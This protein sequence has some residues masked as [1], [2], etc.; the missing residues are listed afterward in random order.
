MAF[1]LHTPGS[2]R[3][4]RTGNSHIATQVGGPQAG[5]PVQV[6]DSSSQRS[7][8]SVRPQPCT[9]R[10]REG[11]ARKAPVQASSLRGTRPSY[12]MGDHPWPRTTAQNLELNRRV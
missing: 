12:K 9:S 3:V 7:A 1:L 4:Q 2:C 10:P 8:A 5:V 11:T 6:S